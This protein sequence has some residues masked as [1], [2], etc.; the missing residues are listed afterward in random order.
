MCLTTVQKRYT[1]TGI[2]LDRLQRIK[3]GGRHRITQGG[4]AEY[5]VCGLIIE[6]KTRSCF[7][8]GPTTV[9]VTIMLNNDDGSQ[10]VE[11]NSKVF[12]AMNGHIPD[13]ELIARICIR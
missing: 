9:Q 4:P 5:Y 11:L 6:T 12:S 1:I 13:D 2:D 7:F 10:L 3:L 8:P